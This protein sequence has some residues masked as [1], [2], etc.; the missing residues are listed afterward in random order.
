M[1]IRTEKKRSPKLPRVSRHGASF[2]GHW[3]ESGIWTGSRG[4]VIGHLLNFSR[5]FHA[6]VTR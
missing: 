3:P 2:L 5:K 1:K 4:S 6:K